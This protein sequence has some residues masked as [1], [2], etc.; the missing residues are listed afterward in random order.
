MKKNN[1]EKTFLELYTE[2]KKENNIQY[3]N[4]I[5]HTQLMMD[6]LKANAFSASMEYF[7][8]QGEMKYYLEVDEQTNS[9]KPLEEIRTIIEKRFKGIDID[10]RKVYLCVKEGDK[11]DLLMKELE[12]YYINGEYRPIPKDRVVINLRDIKSQEYLES[13]VESSNSDHSLEQGLLKGVGFVKI[14]ILK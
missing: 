12:K 4:N 14:E 5:D 13:L 7:L 3:I 6:V 9:E 10:K 2:F 1:E 8:G 11:K